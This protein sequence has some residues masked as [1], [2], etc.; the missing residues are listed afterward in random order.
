MPFFY[1]PDRYYILLVIP[2]MLIALWAQMRVKST[3]AKYSREG[4]YGGLTGAQAARRILD[5]N[6]LTDVRIEPVRGSLTDHYDPRDK[7]VRLSMDVYG[8]DTVAAVGVAAHETGHAIQ[9]AVGYFPLQLRNAI[10]PITNIGSQLSI[11]LVFIGYFLGMQP[12][13][14]LGILLFSLVT[15]FQLITLPVE[16][17]ASRRALA[18][19]D[20]Y[21]MVNDYEHEGV[22]KVLSAAALTYVAALIVSLA[23]LLRLILLF[24]GRRDD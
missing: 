6:G 4:T 24:G 19:L 11:P 20:E 22:R 10:I 1:L 21:G 8:C 23:N 9:H 18:T 7:V 12:L 16:F 15:V 5:A 2:A 13:V 3:F 14:S 17:N